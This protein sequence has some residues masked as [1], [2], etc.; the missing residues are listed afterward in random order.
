MTTAPQPATAGWPLWAWW[1]LASIISY[2]VGTLV[3]T[4][5]VY[6]VVDS[7]DVGVTINL[8]LVL[9]GLGLGLLQWLILRRYIAQAHRWM[10]VTIGVAV[11]GGVG[12]T[13]VQLSVQAIFFTFAFE[14]GIGRWTVNSMYVWGATVVVLTGVMQWLV[15]RRQVP[16]AGWWIPAS[17]AAY[18]S[19]IASGIAAVYMG[20]SFVSSDMF[21]IPELIWRVS[22]LSLIWGAVIGAITG[23]VLVRLLR[24]P[25]VGECTAAA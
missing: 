9:V 3:D 5:V 8:R 12:Y 10:W 17:V 4:A 14:G 13:V 7:A 20:I 19:G 2:F 21:H 1:I 6:P 22:A 24:Q 11:V 23:A 15:L 18:F 25:V 16:R